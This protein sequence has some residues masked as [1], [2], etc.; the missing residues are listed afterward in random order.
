MGTT[1][2][3][4]LRRPQASQVLRASGL[5]APGAWL[6]RLVRWRLGGCYRRVQVGSDLGHDLLGA[7]DPRLPTAFAAGAALA[8]LGSRRGPDGD[9]VPSDLLV[10]GD[11]HG[12]PRSVG[13]DRTY[14]LGKQVANLLARVT[15]TVHRGGLGHAEAPAAADRSARRCALAGS[16]CGL[17]CREETVRSGVA[18]ENR[19]WQKNYLLLRNSL[20]DRPGHP[21]PNWPT[22]L[23]V[24][25]Q[26]DQETAP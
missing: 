25:P 12:H 19:G 9:L 10:D 1:S 4:V 20:Q 16:H 17:E 26:P 2:A 3:G 18:T 11:G 21:V 22:M 15:P 23:H 8:A 14:P 5:E 24:A 6:S 7:A 13:Y